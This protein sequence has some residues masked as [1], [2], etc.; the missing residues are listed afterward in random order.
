MKRLFVESSGFTAQL[1]RIEEGIRILSHVQKLI[2][3]NP[4]AGDVVQGTG[5][6]RKVRIPDPTRGKGTRGGL[7][8]MF[9]DLPDREVTHLLVVF[10][11]GEKDDISSSDKKELKSLVEILKKMPVKGI[12]SK[13]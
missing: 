11:K 3:E 7:R 9:L 10:G 1:K 2:M 4:E 13:R 12:R 6:I 8:V 5:G